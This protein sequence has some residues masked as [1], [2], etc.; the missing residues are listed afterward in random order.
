M[1]YS[2]CYNSIQH[3][4]LNIQYEV[5]N[6]RVF[7]EMVAETDGL[8]LAIKKPSYIIDD[9]ITEIPL[10]NKIFVEHGIIIRKQP[11]KL[12]EIF[13]DYYFNYYKGRFAD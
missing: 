7:R 12:Y 11:S 13:N 3:C 1:C 8:F 6:D 5:D 9:T 10:R 4:T 2:H